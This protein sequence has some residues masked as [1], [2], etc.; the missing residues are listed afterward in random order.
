MCTLPDFKKGTIYISLNISSYN[1]FNCCLL[2][3]KNLIFF[4]AFKQFSMC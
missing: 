4:Y 1:L 2:R 3:I